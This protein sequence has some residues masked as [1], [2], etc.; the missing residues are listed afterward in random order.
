MSVGLWWLAA[1]S[2]AFPLK[3]L[4]PE[5]QACWVGQP[6]V[7]LLFTIDNQQFAAA[8]NFLTL[9]ISFTLPVKSLELVSRP[10]GD[11]IEA[12]GFTSVQYTQQSLLASIVRGS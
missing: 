1:P 10:E 3:G 9:Y 4:M 8:Q 7:A 12:L 6:G 5:E 11:M 2:D